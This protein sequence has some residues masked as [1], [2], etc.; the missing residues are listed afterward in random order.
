MTLAV[1]TYAD[2]KQMVRNVTGRP[3]TASM[4][5]SE[6]GTRINRYYQL[7]LPKQIK[8]FFGYTY[9]N[10]TTV[11]D[12]DQYTPPASFQTLTPSAWADGFPLTWY[13]DPA[14]FFQDYPQQENK[15]DVGTGD[16]ATTAFS[17]TVP[18]TPVLKGSLYVT[19]GTQTFVDDRVGGFTGATGTINYTTGA[20]TITFPV[21]PALDATITE[22]SQSYMANRPQGIL[23]YNNVF[24]LRNVPD[25]VYLI[26]MQGMNYPTAFSSATDV[27]FRPDLGPLIA[28]GTS[29][30]IYAEY[31]QD[32]E[33][34][35][36]KDGEFSRHMD[37][38]MQ[39]TYEEYMSQRAV[40]T[41]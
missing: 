35:K 5:D 1:M 22:S 33:Y 24:T 31:N 21:A 34:M 13:L 8:V 32:D 20:V 14:L 40:P 12:Q 16:G 2:I 38:A 30:Q 3:D 6:L 11:A 37:I 29:L 18:S 25:Q 39:D 19:D 23:Y 9:Y 41:F 26:K 10:F 4:S 17:F 15:A 28:Y 7:I 27:P 36:L